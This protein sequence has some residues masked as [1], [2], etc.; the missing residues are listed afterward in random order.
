MEHQ[1]RCRVGIELAALG[2][3]H[4]GV[5][6]EAAL[7]GALEQHHAGIGQPVGIDGRQRHGG[8]IARFGLGC[9]GQPGGKQPKR[10]VRGGEI[11]SR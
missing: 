1:R 4:V 5:E 6:D 7:V 9:V 10:L 3:F 8:R 2:A 11:T